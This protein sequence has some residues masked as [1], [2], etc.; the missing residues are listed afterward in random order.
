M[1]TFR[2][3]Y[4]L[5]G[6]KGHK[7]EFYYFAVH[8]AGVGEKHWLSEDSAHLH[9]CVGWAKDSRYYSNPRAYLDR[10]IELVNEKYSLRWASFCCSLKNKNRKYTIENKERVA[11]YMG[12]AE[13][14]TLNGGNFSKEPFWDGPIQLP[15]DSELV[16]DP[17][18]LM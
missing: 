17:L 16:L 3:A 10:F 12:K 7:K 13:T 8:E 6:G 15:A 14:G 18:P 1:D 4:G 2:R 5:R 11:R 9:I